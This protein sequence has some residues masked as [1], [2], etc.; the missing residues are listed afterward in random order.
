MNLSAK[1]ILRTCSSLSK[2]LIELHH[3]SKHVGGIKFGDDK[4]VIISSDEGDAL[5]DIPK[6]L[7]SILHHHM[8]LIPSNLSNEVLLSHL[9]MMAPGL[10][11]DLLPVL[12]KAF[13]IDP[14]DRFQDPE[15]LL[16]EIMNGEERDELRSKTQESSS[17]FEYEIGFDTHIGRY[18]SIFSQTNQDSFY[19]AQEQDVILL[20]VLDGISTSDAGSGDVA[21]NIARNVIYQIWEQSKGNLTNASP[22]EIREFLMGAL[23]EANYYICETAK[24]IAGGS[25]ENKTPMGTTALLAVVK[26][27][28]GMIASLGDSRAYVLTES[29][30]AILTGDHNLRG[31]KLR[32][33]MP[34][35]NEQEGFALIR[36]L[37]HFDLERENAAFPMPD[38]RTFTILPGE[39][40]LMCSDGLND[41]AAKS[42]YGFGRILSDSTQKSST[43][44]GCWYLTQKANE[45]GGGDNIT[46]ILAKRLK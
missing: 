16:N 3:Q 43:M 31:E 23:N 40:L 45:G 34:I 4:W 29:G 42:H 25:I 17:D 10:P 28:E 32:Q 20:L 22:E 38:I 19:I 13:A 30:P 2:Q 41:Y 35:M 46:T 26:G 1:D 9:A 11:I 44:E 15:S 7:R 5:D 36:Y 33:G 37:G 21:S 12:N 39:S 8:P 18:K 6:L 24:D 27:S 14:T